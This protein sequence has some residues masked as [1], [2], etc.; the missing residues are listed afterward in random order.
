MRRCL[1]FLTAVCVLAA[2]SCVTLLSHSYD[3]STVDR[4]PVVSESGRTTVFLHLVEP[5]VDNVVV[6]LTH[7]LEDQSGPQGG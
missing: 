5:M 6:D 7:R 3:D 2:P 4:Q 1:L